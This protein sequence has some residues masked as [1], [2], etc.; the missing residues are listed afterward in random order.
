MQKCS[1]SQTLKKSLFEINTF[2]AFQARFLVF[3]SAIILSFPSWVAPFPAMSG[4]HQSTPYWKY[5]CSTW[6]NKADF[7]KFWIGHSC[8]STR[9][10]VL[11][12]IILNYVL[13]DFEFC[14]LK[15][16][17]C[18]ISIYNQNIHVIYCYTFLIVIYW[19]KWNTIHVPQSCTYTVNLFFFQ[20]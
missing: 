8:M 20:Y 4:V 19:S 11:L 9:D 14:S 10:S 7:F 15:I 1:P 17:W 18:I 3:P 16:V 2:M 5:E 12:I 13:D 6:K